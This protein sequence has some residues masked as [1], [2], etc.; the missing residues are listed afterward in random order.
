MKSELR[1]PAPPAITPLSVRPREAAR[2]LGI[3]E[4]LLW[5]WTQHHQIPHVRVGGV[6]LYPVEELQ[7]WLRGQT[8]R[9]ADEPAAAG[10][11]DSTVGTEKV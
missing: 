8:T 1:L 6:V 7:R 4:R 10:L 2:A 11:P 9:G 3:S 5:S